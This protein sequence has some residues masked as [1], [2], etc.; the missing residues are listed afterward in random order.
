M[1]FT[2]G[3]ARATAWLVCVLACAVMS[4]AGLSGQAPDTWQPTSTAGI[5]VLSERHSHTAVWTGTHVIVWGGFGSG[6]RNDGAK[7]DPVTDV[8]TPISMLGAPTARYLHTAVWTGTKMIVWGG[9][10]LNT[11][12]IYDPVTDTW[13]PTSLV[14]APTPRYDH[15]AI[16][17]G[18]RMIVWGGQGSSGFFNTGGA[19][20][21]VNDIWTPLSTVSSPTARTRHTA[22]WTGSTMVVYGGTISG[23]PSVTGS[24]AAYSPTGDT[25]TPIAVGSPRARHSAHW[26]GTRMLVSG[27]VAGVQLYDPALNTWTNGT[28]VGAP[29]TA[30]DRMHCWTGSELFVWGGLAREDSGANTLSN[31][32]RGGALYNPTTNSWRTVA[33]LGAPMGAYN[34]TATTTPSG[35]VIFGGQ[36]RQSMSS[37]QVS[38]NYS[39]GGIYDITQELWLR[40]GVNWEPQARSFHSAVWTGSKMIVWGGLNAST[41]L[42]TGGVYDQTADGWT[43]VAVNGAP[44]PRY[45]HAAVWT[46]THMLIWGGDDGSA[47]NTGAAYNPTTDTW[48]PMGTLG[49]LPSPR[50]NFVHAWTGTELLVW[51]GVGAGVLGD[52]GRYNPMSGVWTA[53]SSVDA[54][55]ARTDT[56]GTWTGDKL[57][58]WGGSSNGASTGRLGTGA[59][60]DP[61]LD[62]WTTMAVAPGRRL[63]S[64]AWTGTEVLTFGGEQDSGISQAT[65]GRYS[66][67]TNTWTSISNGVAWTAL[68]AAASVW[69]GRYLIAYGGTNWNNT[70]VEV[71]KVAFDTNSNNWASVASLQPGPGKR[72]GVSS[73]WTGSRV[74]HW[75]GRFDITHGD[76]SDGYIYNPGHIATDSPVHAYRRMNWIPQFLPSVSGAGAYA[77]SAMVVWGGRGHGSHEIRSTANRYDI[78]M[79]SWAS[80][81]TS[82]SGTSRT[83]LS[84]HAI[85]ADVFFVGGQSTSSQ[86]SLT[87]ISSVSSTSGSWQP[88]MATS[89]AVSDRLLQASATSGSQ[90]LVYGG[91]NWNLTASNNTGALYTIGTNSWA[92]VPSTGPSG[93][94]VAVWTGDAFLVYGGTSNNFIQSLN[95]TTLSWTP[96]NT[97]GAPNGRFRTAGVWTGSYLVVFGGYFSSSLN[98]PLNTGGRYDPMNN[99]WAPTST[100][101]APSPRMSHS[102]IWTGHRMIIYGGVGPGG[103]ILGD[104]G[105]YDPVTDTWEPL[106]AT[107]MPSPRWGHVCV[108]TGRSMIVWGGTSTGTAITGSDHTPLHTGG[109]Y[110]PP[111]IAVSLQYLAQPQSVTAYSAVAQ[112]L[113]VRVL[114]Q[115]GDPMLSDNTSTIRLILGSNPGGASLRLASAPLVPVPHIDA[116]AVNGVV[117]FPAFTVNAGGNGYTLQV[118]GVSPGLPAVTSNTFNV[119]PLPPLVI[120]NSSLPVGATGV[121]YTNATL[122]ATGGFGSGYTWAVNPALPAGL[123]LNPNTGV[124]SGTPNATS[125]QSYTFTLNDG[126]YSTAA[127]KQLTLTVTLPLQIT[128]TAVLPLVETVIYFQNLDATGGLG[129][130]TWSIQSGQLPVG[131]SLHPNGNALVAAYLHGTPASGTAQGGPY[132][133]TLAVTDGAFTA[134]LPV[135]LTVHPLIPLSL[136]TVSIPQADE[137]IPYAATLNA[138]GGSMIY[139]WSVDPNSMDFLPAGLTLNPNTGGILGT[140]GATSAG[141]YNITFEVSDG[142][143]SA[144]KLLPL[145]V[146]PPLLVTTAA[147]P[148]VI[149]GTPYSHTLIATGGSGAPKTWSVTPALPTGL[150]LA[151]AT[152][153]ISGTPTAQSSTTHTFTV[154]DGISLPAN[155][156]LTITIH[157]ALNI[158]TATLPAGAVGVSYSANLAATGGSGGPRTWSVSPA[159]PTGL[160]LNPT[161]GAITGTPTAANS[162]SRNFTVNDGVVPQASQ[163]ILLTIHPVLQIPTSTLPAGAVGVSYAGA[164]LAATGG[165]GGPYSWSVS[166][167]LPGGLTLNPS[168]GAITGT[169]TVASSLSHSFTVNDGI[170]APVNKPL[171]LTV[172]PVLSITTASLPIAGLGAAYSQTLAAAGGNGGP[173]SWSVSPPLP[174]GLTLNPSTGA[175]TGTASAQSSASYTFTVNDGISAPV[176]KPLQL[177]VTPMLVVSTATLPAG[178]VGVSYSQTLSGSGGT[179][180]PYTWSVSPPLASGLTLNLNSGAITGTPSVASNLT[181]TFTLNDGVSPAATKQLLLTIHPVLNVTTAALPAGAVGVAYSQSLAA[182]GGNGGPYTWSVSPPLASGLSLNPSTG[183]ITGT[184]TAASTASYNFTVNDG[185]SAPVSVSRPLTIHPVLQI[186]T[187]SLPAGNVGL[188]Y[189]ASLAA[190][191]GN[192]GPYTWSVN[193]ALPAG[194]TLNPSTGAITGTPTAINNQQHSFSVNAG[195]S[196]SVSVNLQ[197]TIDLALPA[198]A[199]V[200]ASASGTYGPGQTIQ[201]DRTISNSGQSSGTVQYSL[202]LSSDAQITISDYFLGNGSA[203]IAASASDST[204]DIVVMPTGVPMGGYYVGMILFGPDVIPSQDRVAS[205]LTGIWA[206]PVQHTLAVGHIGGPRAANT[207]YMLPIRFSNTNAPFATQV[208]FNLDIGTPELAYDNHFVAGATGISINAF[209]NAGGVVSVTISSA[210]PFTD[211]LLAELRFRIPPSVGVSA[212]AAVHTATVTDLSVTDPSSTVQSS[213]AVNGSITLSDHRIVAGNASGSIQ[214]NAEIEVPV[215]LDNITSS[216]AIAG[217]QF[218]LTALNP[219]LEYLSFTTGAAATAAGKTASV[220]GVGSEATV[221]I[222]GLNSNLIGSGELVKIKFRVKSTG[223]QAGDYAA[224]I[225]EIIASDNSPLSQPVLVWNVDG[226]ISLTAFNVR[227]VNRDGMIN[228]LDVQMT[229]NIVLS[230]LPPQYPGQGDTNGDNM[231]NVLDIQNI[232]NCILNSANCG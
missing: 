193:P 21:P 66:F 78:A 221:L 208:Q 163:S 69:T 117:T 146:R 195:I 52:G 179:G 49:A 190:T 109:I 189:S 130:Y 175:I 219:D 140:P 75:G 108:W 173:Y 136:T 183:A 182:T 60:Y 119:T 107:S 156:Q 145:T 10:T 230:L 196:A 15:T 153:A 95:P 129:A 232:V 3:K 1:R 34:G 98:T 155:K 186:S 68:R 101:G 137:G 192:G 104:G 213:Q 194:L 12:G 94:S 123:T 65:G 180:G 14:G 2:F 100:I 211:G 139:T 33:A 62:T 178:G 50:R 41:K 97:S 144:P 198:F 43:P 206:V 79:G 70:S 115:H 63:H 131:L 220:N 103:V 44:S 203:T 67:G 223:A 19:Y 228:V 135:V 5:G 32:V 141:T 73:I 23:N 149:I 57:V 147:L 45:Q 105:I 148:V 71:T 72:Y 165:N 25:W 38:A 118:E 218:K 201:V 205:P 51:G 6:D 61:Q 142:L 90:I 168:T 29:Q 8:W 48:S 22:V 88:D 24:G 16:W 134:S 114:D 4:A 9:V 27:Y 215:T 55:S 225:S 46:G 161:T 74:I 96:L 172:H 85:G 207:T 86:S 167:P 113:T 124:I 39:F 122:Q 133:V 80:L 76:V 37:G 217:I 166:P 56:P 82:N 120:S 177:T 157:P 18:T 169:P 170:S 93:G 112:G 132:P 143:G 197:L 59:Y 164:T 138:T 126:G 53:M 54:P 99:S 89:T 188:A 125:S 159:L 210:T 174:S 58:V 154:S 202:Y 36:P 47:T 81:S 162:T 209:A 226:V 187:T 7:Y 83:G 171:Q 128:T 28:V 64:M 127:N 116:T 158:T 11:G 212:T 152:G 227:D 121:A 214:A 151:P 160:T 176:N 26:S 150:S 17:T 185:I 111:Q 84:A 110:T 204:P 92:V 231:V 35:I 181:H 40:T 30:E 229:V 224:V 77:G 13:A 199:A 20:D 106:P 91:T 184:P 42:G 200:S 216:P 222:F 31:E 191:G 102:A 87:A